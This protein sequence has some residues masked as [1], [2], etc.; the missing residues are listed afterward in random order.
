MIMAYFLIR[1]WIWPCCPKCSWWRFRCQ[2][3]LVNVFHLKATMTTQHTQFAHGCSTGV[4]CKYLDR[5]R[6][7]TDSPISRPITMATITTP[8]IAN[9][10]I[11]HS[12]NPWACRLPSMIVISVHKILF[13]GRPISLPLHT[14]DVNKVEVIVWILNSVQSVLHTSSWMKLMHLCLFIA[15]YDTIILLSIA[16]LL[17]WAFKGGSTV[18]T[19]WIKLCTSWIRCCRSFHLK[20]ILDINYTKPFLILQSV[21]SPVGLK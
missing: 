10:I 12:G 16:L 17:A 13:I 18:H 2:N 6:N 4:Q 8:T 19:F 7:A 21:L 11:V 15:H 3:I 20:F 1:K 5:F 9:T 14:V